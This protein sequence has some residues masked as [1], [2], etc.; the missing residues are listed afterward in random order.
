M[1]LAVGDGY[2]AT[3]EWW[4]NEAG[5]DRR[6]H[7]ETLVGPDDGHRTSGSIIA[8]VGP[9]RLGQGSDPATATPVNWA[10]IQLSRRWTS[11]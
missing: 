11:L 6:C 8:E 4:R 9:E 7:R 2:N 3:L 5:N 10:I 1:D